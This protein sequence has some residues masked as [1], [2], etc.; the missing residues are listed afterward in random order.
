[1]RHHDVVT[2]RSIYDALAAGNYSS[3]RSALHPDAALPADCDWLYPDGLWREEPLRFCDLGEG[4]VL[5]VVHEVPRR[6]RTPKTGLLLEPR[7]V[8]HG[9]H[10]RAGLVV[11]LIVRPDHEA[12]LSEEGLAASGG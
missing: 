10:L 2:V 11:E 7:I 3:A 8:A 1:M 5:V 12:W 9:W 6:P 4:R